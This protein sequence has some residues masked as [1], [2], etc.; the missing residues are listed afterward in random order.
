M[1]DDLLNK[2]I[3]EADELKVKFKSRQL[4]LKEDIDSITKYKKTITNKITSFCKTFREQ[5]KLLNR[6]DKK[7][8]AA[9]NEVKK[10]NDQLHSLN[11][12]LEKERGVK[13][14]YELEVRFLDHALAASEQNILEAH[15]EIEELEKKDKETCKRL[16]QLNDMDIKAFEEEKDKLEHI[17]KEFS[18]IEFEK[19]LSDFKCLSQNIKSLFNNGVDE[20]E[21]TCVICRQ[22]QSEVAYD[23]CGHC[24][25][26]SYC[27][28]KYKEK[29]PY[30]N[31][32]SS[33]AIKI[34]NV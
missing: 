5:E 10:K 16:K 12:S 14:Q 31:V 7:L 21:G 17:K 3:L 11:K 15:L 34:Y 1:N 20:I 9:L 27:Y 19:C 23:P 18:K 6:L 22:S 13:R 24:C 32:E 4:I 26:C 28:E 25:V 29:C 33:S 30:C 8:Y 2:M